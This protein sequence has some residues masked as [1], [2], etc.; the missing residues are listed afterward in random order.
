MQKRCVECR[1]PYEFK[2]GQNP[3]WCPECDKARIER[4]SKQFDKLAQNF[5]EKK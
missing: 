1:K 5:G 3:Y 2:K 4:V